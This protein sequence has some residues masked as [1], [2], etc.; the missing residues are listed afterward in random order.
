VPHSAD[1][2]ATNSGVFPNRR[3]GEFTLVGV[4]GEG[5]SATVYDARWG[6]RSIAL[7]VLRAELG[8]ADRRGVGAIMA[9]GQGLRR[10]P[11]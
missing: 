7:K 6:H 3:L 9:V 8:D 10:R 1:P 4:L 11:E 2:I 5:G